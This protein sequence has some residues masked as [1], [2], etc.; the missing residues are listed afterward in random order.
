MKAA[1]ITL[2]YN[3]NNYGGIAQA[4]AL[5]KY[6][7]SQ[8]VDAEVLLYKRT[9]PPMFLRTNN[10][11]RNKFRN[12][13]R[14]LNLKIRNKLAQKKYHNSLRRNFLL[15]E[16][17]FEVSR[18]MIKHSCLYTDETINETAD[19]YDIF[20]SGSD[21]IWKPGTIREA[22]VA[23]FLPDWKK[24]ISYASSISMK[25]LSD[26]YGDFMKKMLSKYKYISVREA[27]A[28]KY[29]E[30]L[31]GRQVETVLDPTLLLPDNVWNSV[32]T[33][34]NKINDRYMFVYMLGDNLQQR[35]HIR[36]TAEERN[37]KI[38]TLPHI[39][40]YVRACDIG[41]GDTELYDIDLPEFL[42]LIKNAELV[43]TD[44]FHAVIFSNIFETE[45]FLYERSVLDDQYNMNSRLET[46]LDIFD[47]RQRFIDIHTSITELNE[48]P[49]LNFGRIK[50]I[51]DKE[52]E[53]S[54][55]WLNTA[56]FQ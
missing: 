5:Q 54:Q 30:G 47:E 52:K 41:F 45:F 19:K 11:I 23:G 7:E 27:D 21:Q 42:G 51:L 25:G 10:K 17:A 18:N 8:G 36:K 32:S 33:N 31:L 28:A 50:D 43:C 35:K 37:L 13:P 38:V 26:E 24:R 53:K 46:L 40:G 39:E 56:L 1:I 16:K 48:M 12:F 22:F 15:R 49:T 6:I 55:K 3:N 44:S 14:K 29:L 9:S 4:W 2:Y 34:H 20:I